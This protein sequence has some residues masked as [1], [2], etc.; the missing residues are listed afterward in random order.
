MYHPV[1]PQGKVTVAGSTRQPRD[2]SW[3]M[4]SVEIRA[5]LKV[6]APLQENLAT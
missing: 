2:V 5:Q 4:F 6:Q 3:E 1:G